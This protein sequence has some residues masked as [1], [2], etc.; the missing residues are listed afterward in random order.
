MP[1]YLLFPPSLPQSPLNEGYAHEVGTT[2]LTSQVELGPAKRRSR[3]SRA[4]DRKSLSYLLTTE[5]RDTLS[6]FV[7]ETL[8]QGVR[9]F[10]LPVCVTK[11]EAGGTG[12][13]ELVRLIPVSDTALVQFT[14]S[15]LYWSVTLQVE[16]LP[17]DPNITEA[18][19]A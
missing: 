6:T 2:L 13:Y 1:N 10:L 7:T 16:V 15:G 11:H 12:G 8:T 18:Q 4:V 17:V 19:H 14:R 5:Q 3:Q 9:P